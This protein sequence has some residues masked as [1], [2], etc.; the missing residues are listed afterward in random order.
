[1]RRKMSS[2]F[3]WCLAS[4][5]V[6][7]GCGDFGDAL[8][9]YFACEANETRSCKCKE[10]SNGVQLCAPDGG[11]WETC[12]CQDECTP[13]SEVCDGIDNDC[14]GLTDEDAPL[15]YPDNDSDG[16]GGLDAGFA[17]CNEPDGGYV[18][19]GDDCDDNDP[20]H[21]T[22][23]PPDCDT[24]CVD[25]DSDDYGDNCDLGHDCDDNDDTC[26]GECIAFYLDDDGDGYGDSSNIVN[27]CTAPSNNY[28]TNGD[29]CDDDIEACGEYCHPGLEDICDGYDNDCNEST[30]DGNICDHGCDPVAKDCYAECNPASDPCCY[31]EGTSCEH[32]C[33]GICDSWMDD[34]WDYRIKLTIHPEK[35][36][37]NLSNFPVFVDLVDLKSHFF[38]TLDDNGNNGNE[39]RVTKV[40]GTSEVPF[41]VNLDLASNRGELH[42]KADSLSG[43]TDTVFYIYYGNTAAG[44]YAKSDPLGADNVWDTNYIGVWHF[45]EDPTNSD[46][47]D[48]TSGQRNGIVSAVTNTPVGLMGAADLF[49][50]SNSYVQIQNNNQDF[51]FAGPFTLGIW[52]FPTN[53]ARN[54]LFNKGNETLAGG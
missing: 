17:D 51:N 27:A 23:T 33:N 15:W 22:G 25:T 42:F 2:F 48:S 8:K 4:G 46:L 47:I 16:H 14:D 36:E 54:E 3:L 13:G 49:S 44:A 37:S 19:E 35:V 30:A 50:E 24:D 45:E 31:S 29:D 39:I 21:W 32:C 6:L 9:D 52:V 43:V 12:I 41:E 20:A 26:T 28:V 18:L 53:G 40:D 34:N 1:M 10:G 7:A 11:A 38:H 5:F